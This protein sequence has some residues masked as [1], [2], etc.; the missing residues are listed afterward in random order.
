MADP[1]KTSVIGHRSFGNSSLSVTP[2]S[3]PDPA[4]SVTAT[5]Q[6]ASI[7]CQLEWS[8]STSIESDR[9]PSP[10]EVAFATLGWPDRSFKPLEIAT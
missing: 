4:H 1:I 9:R 3:F 6:E 8:E 7:H 2:Q 10:V 5:H